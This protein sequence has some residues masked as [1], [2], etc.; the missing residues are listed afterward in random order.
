MKNKTVKI[1]S[2]ILIWARQSRGFKFYDVIEHFNK[3]TKQKFGINETTLKDLE[4]KGEDEVEINFTLLKEFAF[5]YKRPLSVFFIDKPLNDKF[6]PQNFRTLLSRVNRELSPDSFLIFRRVERTREFILEVRESLKLNIE[7]KYKKVN[8]NDDPVALGVT[9]RKEFGIDDIKKIKEGKDYFEF[10]RDKMEGLGIF[11]LQYSFPL[12]DARAFSIVDTNPYVIVLNNKDGNGTSYY[13]KIF[14]LMHEFA[15]VLLGES[16]IE[17]DDLINFNHIKT[18]KFC[19]DFASEF[20]IPKDQFI[21]QLDGLIN[22]SGAFNEKTIDHFAEK[23]SKRFMVSKYV[24]L[25]KF[26]D[27][28]KIDNAFYE[29]KVREWEDAFRKIKKVKKFIPNVPLEIRAYKNYGKVFS[30]IVIKAEGSNLINFN[31]AANL[32]GLK[33]KSFLRLKEYFY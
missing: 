21:S 9:F 2:I 26:L 19:N 32:L 31:N 11:V 27:I 23:L 29:N 22:L 4:N 6:I 25:K 16:S 15:H 18:E 5:L 17:N 12:D 28:K 30:T 3:K 33:E 7:F 24:I 13:P 14:S 20:L 8:K 1:K 10:L